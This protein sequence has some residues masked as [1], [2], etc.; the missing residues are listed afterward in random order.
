MN[1]DNA[2][3]L[4]LF[5]PYVGSLGIWITGRDPNLRESITLATALMLL[6]SVLTLLP[7]VASGERPSLTL[8]QIAPGLS[9]SFTIEPLGML[10]AIVA[11]GLW[12]LNSVYSIGYMRGN[13]EKNQTRFYICFAI[14]IASAM[15]IAFAGNMLTLFIFYEVLTLSTYPLVTHKGNED[16]MRSGRVYLGILLST[17]IGF[18]LLAVIWT[19]YLAGTLDFTA[20]GILTGKIEGLLLPILLGLYMFGIGKAALM[21][22]HRWLP[23]AMVA[24]TPVSALLH[25]VAVV[26]AGV[27]TVVKVTVYIFG[28]DL[29]SSTGAS[30]WLVWVAAITLT[31]ASLIALSKD[32]LKARL[33]YSTVSQLSYVVL[34]A[35]LAT[36]MGVMGGA[37]QIA[38]HAVG[39]ITLFFC[40]GAIYTATHKTE[41]SQM[42][43]L[44]RVMPF[45]YGAFLIG[46]L[47]IIGL[48][49]LGGSWS[50][51]YLMVGAADAGQLIM[52][53]VLMLSSLLNVAYLLPIVAR[54][55]FLPG[56]NYASQDE[57][58]SGIRRSTIREAPLTCV[59]PLS[60]TAI[61]CIL[62]F[63][64]ADSLYDLLQ[65]IVET[66]PTSTASEVTP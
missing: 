1:P 6:I 61:G 12:P 54:G 25:A 20:G 7:A 34:G 42:D 58:T 14:A 36:T 19:W 46:S 53:G 37:L 33:A 4:A 18:L 43:G 39:K 52:I 8:L 10:F 35:M 56:P 21:P 29:L 17:S 47:S 50:K 2:I 5:L 48:P 62:L 27:F 55:F 9:L 3:L 30:E 51:W 49:P 11:A 24:P 60:I 66:P 16:A 41:I 31:L 45:T 15:G 26:K 40:A 23:A 63:F 65:P 64:F 22:F 44:G 28:I 38:M 59:I 32:N 57:E 13:Q